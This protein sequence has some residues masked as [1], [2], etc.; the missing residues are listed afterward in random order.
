MLWRREIETSSE[1]QTIQ[2]GEA[3][4]RR[5]EPG[6]TVLLI[7]ELGAGKTRLAKGIVF[8]AIGVPHDEVVSPTFTLIHRFEGNFPVHHADLYRLQSDQVEG[9]GLDDALEE[10]GAL[11]VEWAERLGQPDPEALVVTILDAGG[12]DSRRIVMESLAAGHWR[13]RMESIAREFLH[14]EAVIG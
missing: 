6:D 10:G 8:A 11:I 13:E 5:L 7:G 3:I 2:V 1:A 12:A 4:G 9:I 14:T